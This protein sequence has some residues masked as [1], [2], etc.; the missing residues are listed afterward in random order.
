V[1]QGN[2][3]QKNAI[4]RR[5]SVLCIQTL[6]QSTF[7]PK[8][9]RHN[10]KQSAA[11]FLEPAC[12]LQSAWSQQADRGRQW[13]HPSSCSRPKCSLGTCSRGSCATCWLFTAQAPL[14][15]ASLAVCRLT[16]AASV[17]GT[18]VLPLPCPQGPCPWAQA[19]KALAL[20]R[21]LPHRPVLLVPA[22]WHCCRCARCPSAAVAET[23]QQQQQAAAYH[24]VP[25]AAGRCC[26]P[27]LLLLLL[28][29]QRA[30][31][32]TAEQPD[33]VSPW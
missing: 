26:L 30:A 33:S 18:H 23:C 10:R 19:P 16:S 11:H 7:G 14:A 20:G 8:T 1:L 31:L 21:R 12:V 22:N 4:E 25:S 9:H 2:K 28:L 24:V 29:L 6:P 32:H 3:L 17:H 15:L 13:H 5:N 27:A